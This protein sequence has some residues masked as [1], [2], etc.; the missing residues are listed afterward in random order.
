MAKPLSPYSGCILFMSNGFARAMAKVAEPYFAELG[1]SMTQAFLLM[2]VVREPGISA[3]TLAGEVLL[4]PSTVTRALDKMELKRLVYRESFRNTISVF[5][6]PEGM[7]LEKDAAAAWGKVQVYYQA[8]FTKEN[9]DR[10]AK[11]LD[12]GLA[13]MRHYPS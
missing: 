10:W 2:S 8:K 6:S 1:L 9:S 13:W 5:P 7:K 12:E 3:G 4:D 11:E